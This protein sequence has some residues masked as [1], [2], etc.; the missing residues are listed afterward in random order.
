MRTDDIFDKL[1]KINKQFNSDNIDDV[2][3]EF[4]NLVYDVVLNQDIKEDFLAY[5]EKY[6][7]KTWFLFAKL[8]LM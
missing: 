5:V 4:H 6:F 8:N 2:E 7:P 3:K 1:K